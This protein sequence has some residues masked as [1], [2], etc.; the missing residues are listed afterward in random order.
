[1]IKTTVLAALCSMAL[2]AGCYSFKGISIPEGAQTFRAGV[3]E[4]QTR[5]TTPPPPTIFNN[6][7]EE[8]KDKIRNET[9]LDLIN[10]DADIEFTGA[11][12]RFD[13]SYEAPSTNQNAIGGTSGAFNRL[14]I[15]VEVS[16]NYRQDVKKNWKQTFSFYD[17]FR[18]DQNLVDVQDELIN[19]IFEQILE[20]IFQKAFG[21]W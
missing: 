8:L 4:D 18:S 1:M 20:Q 6:F 5:G 15:A 3:F 16:Y 12:T 21:D 19:N 2:L 10:S 9:R 17:D 14:T 11:I 7:T 13:V